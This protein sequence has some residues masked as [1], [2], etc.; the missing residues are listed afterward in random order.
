M[1]LTRLTIGAVLVL[2]PALPAQHKQETEGHAVHEAMAGEMH[3]SAH[4]ELTPSRRATAG[5]SVR[6]A[7][8]VDS[9]RRAIAQFADTSAATAAGYRL[10]LPNLKSQRVFH[11]THWGRAIG[12]AFRF[13]PAKPTSLLY[14]RGD[15][16]KLVLVGAMYG[17]PK[18]LSAEQLDERVPLSIARWHKHVNLC[19][20]Q[21]GDENRWMEKG[22]DGAPKFGPQG[23][24]VTEAQCNRAGGRFMPSLFGW[25]VH[26]NAFEKDPWAPEHKH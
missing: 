22:T 14:R 17:A 18:R 8:L 5:D 6:A 26:V 20:P 12:E 23:S 7:V 10:F 16:G 24:I 13:D 1:R 21:K 15:D 9:L 19:L 25:M 4:L 3:A 2:A 11:F